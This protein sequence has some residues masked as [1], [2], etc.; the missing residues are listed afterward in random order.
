MRVQDAENIHPDTIAQASGLRFARTQ[1]G[2]NGRENVY[3]SPLRKDNKPSLLINLDTGKFY[4]N[5]IDFGSR[6]AINFVCYLNNIDHTDPN[7][8]RYALK[9]LDSLFGSS[10]SPRLSSSVKKMPT[11]S[12]TSLK[13]NGAS[14]IEVLE[15]KPLFSY[16]LKDYLRDTRKLN[17]SIITKYVQEAECKT[18]KGKTFFGIASPAG[19]DTYVIRNKGRDENGLKLVAGKNLDI[20]VYEHQSEEVLLFEGDI[21]FYTYLTC[22]KIRQLKQTAIVL[23]SVV[24]VKR[25]FNYLANNPNIKRVLVFRDNDNAGKKLLQ[26]LIESNQNVDIIDQAPH[27]QAFKDLNEWWCSR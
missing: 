18:Q 1:L 8:C 21:D 24:M 2:T 6:G 13:K 3:H 20:T 22:K 11:T 10:P 9:I 12:A 26:D 27:Y 16:S 14:H 4:D 15:L 25:F 7:A 5:G 19:E 17:L 23:N